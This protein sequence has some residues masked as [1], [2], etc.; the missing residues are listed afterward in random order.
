MH[1]D[2]LDAGQRQWCEQI[3]AGEGAH[4]LMVARQR[5]KSYAMLGLACCECQ[6][7][8]GTI[9][10]YAALTGKSAAAIALPTLRAIVET[11]PEELRPDI[12]E[13]KGT[14]TFPNGSVL[15][16]AG[17]DAEQFDRLRGPKAHLILLD[18]CAFYADLERVESALLPQLTTTQGRVV[19]LSTPP[20][21]PAHPFVAR[22]NAACAVGR[23][24]HATVH[25]NPR[26]G[27]GGV[28][29]LEASE[30][31]RLGMTVEALRESTYWRREYLAEIVTE[32]S[33]AAV[34]AWT[35]EAHAVIVQ[36]VAR[37]ERFDGYVGLDVGFNPDPHALLLG[38][39]DFPA[40][41]VV[42]EYEMELRGHTV[43]QL[44][45]AAKA[46]E[47][48]AW[49]A[50]KWDGTLSAAQTWENLPEWLAGK[51]HDRAPAQPYMRV[52]D[53]NVLV[54]AELA[55]SHGYAVLPTR[56]DDK[57]LA[58]DALNQLVVQ[59]RLRIHPRCVR[60]VEQLY[61]TVWNKRRSG[62]ERTAKDHGDL[63]DALVYLVRNVAWHRDVRPKPRAF[64][65]VAPPGT[66]SPW[67]ALGRRP[68]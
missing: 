32:E 19:Y 24:I 11:M 54:L 26:L 14:V 61:S 55:G 64:D 67:A 4:V 7:V 47:A 23:G 63:I 44:A 5:G 48:E 35:R 15:T 56:K 49:G 3:L 27:P 2:F 42:I 66:V 46:K 62:W 33:R 12:R 60:L 43:A 52:G 6:R 25:E 9:V 39:Y 68:R 59:R 41:T 57:H 36:E 31:N 53:D 37:P 65:M 10:R 21:S 17:T 16:W 40:S 18:E 28:A 1:P 30:A 38:W 29:A 45:E 51:G 58:V 8:P 20:E 34:P 13:D 22:Y 50:M